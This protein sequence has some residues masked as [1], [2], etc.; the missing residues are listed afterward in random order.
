MKLRNIL[1]LLLL[2]LILSTPALAAGVKQIGIK[3]LHTLTEANKGKVLVIN[4]W[5][6]WC[7]PC[8]QEFP[9]IVALR[10]QFPEKDLTIIGISVDNNVRPVE[11]FIAQHKVNFPIYLDNREIS[12]MLSISSIPRTVIY[13]RSG[14]KVLDHIGIISGDS[15][16]H[17]V[18]ELL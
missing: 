4:Y 12:A 17:L 6:T 13:D 1:V 14:K 15:F 11:N 3:E 9:G 8:V 5:A 2:T 18:Q 10:N 7:A 16:R